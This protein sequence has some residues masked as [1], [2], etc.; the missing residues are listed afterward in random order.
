[1][2]ATHAERW[3]TAVLPSLA[4]AGEPSVDIRLGTSGEPLVLDKETSL[5]P[6]AIVV[7]ANPGEAMQRFASIV[8][9]DN[10][11]LR[12]E[13]PISPMGWW[14]WNVFFDGVTAQ[15]VLDNADFVKANLPNLGFQLIELDDGYQTKWGLW[16]SHQADK[17]PG[18]LASLSEKLKAKGFQQGLWLAP[19]LVDTTTQLAKD[20]PSWFLKD[21][22][23][24][25]VVHRNAGQSFSSYILDPT[26]PE[27]KAHLTNLFQRLAKLGYV[28]FKLDFLFTGAFQG[29]RHDPKVTGVEAL[30]LGLDIIHKAAPQAHINLCGMPIW[31]GIGRGHSIRYGPDIAFKGLNPGF[32]LI[33]HEARNSMVRSPFYRILINDPDQVLVREPLSMGEARVAATLGALTG[34][35]T[36]GDDLTKLS[37]ERL[38]LVSNATLLEIAKLEQSAVPLDWFG[39]TGDVILSPVVDLGANGTPTT[40]VPSQY[41]LKANDKVAYLGLFNWT[42]KIQSFSVEPA[43]LLSTVT[44]V[45]DVWKDQSLQVNDSLTLE[46]PTHDVILLK[47][48]AP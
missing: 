3:R 36:L 14:S 2:G 8:E 6:L 16:E 18:G 48:S 11:P 46:V 41:F 30:R 39:A 45:Q 5:E 25:L 19:F 22:E 9:K 35:Y 29:K 38:A 4:K 37:K 33:A 40:A 24:K 17:F 43:D 27:V 28:W 32:K 20:N 34:F 13:T 44:T 26:H 21:S 31:P 15:Q 10:P 42:D 1:M 47:L 7:G 23:D 12:Q